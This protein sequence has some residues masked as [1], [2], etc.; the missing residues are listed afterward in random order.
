[1]KVGFIGL[2]NVGGKLSGSL[3]RNGIDLSVLDLNPDLVA[4]AVAKGA[5]AGNTAAALM[6]D[7]D[8]VIT[9]LPS[10]DASDTVMQE[11]LPE[12]TAGK[13]WMELSTTDQAE[14]ERLG[15]MVI[16][17]GGAAVD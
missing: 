9:C 6:R 8:A 12:V 2:G 11:R 16:A 10:P 14:A 7:C 1:M 13:I 3:L 4:A 17:A 5:K 15:G